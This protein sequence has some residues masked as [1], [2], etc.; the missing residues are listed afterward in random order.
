[1]LFIRREKC[2]GSSLLRMA[3]ELYLVGVVVRDMLWPWDDPVPR[4][5]YDTVTWSNA[6]A[7]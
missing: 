7:V 3:A 1:M 4:D 6:V 2:G 5:G